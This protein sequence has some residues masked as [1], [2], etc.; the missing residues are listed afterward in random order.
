MK[1]QAFFDS[2][3]ECARWASNDD[4]DNPL[5]SIENIDREMSGIALAKM[6][7]DCDRFLTENEKILEG[8]DMEKAGHN[9][10]LTRNHHGAGFWNGDYEENVGE[11]LT[12]ACE[13]FGEINL[14]VG[15]DGKLY[16]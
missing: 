10:W 5:D 3:L 8:L 7:K 1:N 2:Y 11:I 12:K 15:D 9:F 14:Y 6:E 4:N 16:L 13:S